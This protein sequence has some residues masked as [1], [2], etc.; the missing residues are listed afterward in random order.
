M[1]SVMHALEA[2]G[3]GYI[4]TS[5]SLE[6]LILQSGTIQAEGLGK[7]IEK[8]GD[9]IES[10]TYSSWERF[11]TQ[12]LENLTQ[13][14]I[15]SYSKK[16]LNPAYLTKGNLDKMKKIIENIVLFTEN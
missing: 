11:F 1:Q 15:Y 14:T 13:N 12:L 2:S 5:E 6:Y 7:I 8:P 9:Y 16:K 3:N 10:G 4:W